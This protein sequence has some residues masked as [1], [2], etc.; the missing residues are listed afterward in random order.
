M[1]DVIGHVAYM[2]L[3]LGMVLLSRRNVYGWLARFVGSATWLGLG[4]AMDMSSIWLW[5]AVFAVVD[6]SGWR[7]WRHNTKK[8]TE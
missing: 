7:T 2:S 4:I 8:E 6:I 5:S 1:I 3:V